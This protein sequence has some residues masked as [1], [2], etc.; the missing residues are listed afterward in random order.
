MLL[1]VLD[2]RLGQKRSR[3]KLIFLA[4]VTSVSAQRSA[5]SS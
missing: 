1:G 4:L 3:A 2:V 5:G